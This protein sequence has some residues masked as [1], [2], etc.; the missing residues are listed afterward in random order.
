MRY[1]I[2]CQACGHV[3]T[4]RDYDGQFPFDS[5]LCMGCSRRFKGDLPHEPGQAG[6]KEWSDEDEAAL[7]TVIQ[8][9]FGHRFAFTIERIP[10]YRFDEECGTGAFLTAAANSLN[11]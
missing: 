1:L 11:G 8:F 3:E 4:L 7:A 6:R 2:S 5:F 10:G 9:P